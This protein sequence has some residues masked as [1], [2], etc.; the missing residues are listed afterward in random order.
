MAF[1]QNME[2][3]S[4]VVNEGWTL[5]NFSNLCASGEDAFMGHKWLIFAMQQTAFPKH[6]PNSKVSVGNPVYLPDF[7]EE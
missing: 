2:E 3:H 1:K 4:A 5:L 7:T 6:V